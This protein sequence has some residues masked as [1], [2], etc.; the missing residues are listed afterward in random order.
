MNLFSINSAVIRNANN[1]NYEITSINY[2]EII[3][4]I[5][6][7]ERIL[8]WNYSWKNISNSWKNISNSCDHIYLVERLNLEWNYS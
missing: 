1:Q 8:E 7:F 4:L 6:R 5:E 3:Y 2:V